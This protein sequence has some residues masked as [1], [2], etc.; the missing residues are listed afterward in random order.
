MHAYEVF[1]G[2]LWR[3]NCPDERSYSVLSH[4]HT[5]RRAGEEHFVLTDQG[6]QGEK[7]KIWVDDAP[8]N[9]VDLFIEGA[10][11][12]LKDRIKDEAMVIYSEE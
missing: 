2:G 10:I 9:R 3:E 11:S 7:P 5:E 12:P 4:G 8:G 6:Y 1:Q